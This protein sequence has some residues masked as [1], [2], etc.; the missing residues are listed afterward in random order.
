MTFGENSNGQIILPQGLLSRYDCLFSD[1]TQKH[2]FQVL[3][4][5]GISDCNSYV[6]KCLRH[7]NE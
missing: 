7:G 4:S 2:V 1:E 5:E 6:S 3:V